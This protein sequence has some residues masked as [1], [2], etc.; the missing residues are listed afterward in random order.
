MWEH[1]N[2]LFL[3]LKEARAEGTWNTRPHY[4]SRLIIEGVHLFQGIT[5]STMGH[6]EGWQFLQIGRFL[7]RAG[8][9]AE[10]I[11]FHFRDDAISAA[12]A[13]A[14]IP[15]PRTQIALAGLLRSCSAL[16]AYCRVYTANLRAD[17]IAEF[18]LL[19]SDFPHSVRFAAECVESSLRARRPA[20]PARSRRPGRTAGGPAARVT[21]LRTGRRDPERQPAPVPRRHRAPVSADS[22]RRAP[23]LYRVSDRNG[24]SGVKKVR[25]CEVRGAKCGAKCIV[26]RCDV[27]CGVAACR[28]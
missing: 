13:T 15:S 24:D 22:Q 23:D 26:R 8:A 3:R 18:L 21:R 6:G 7:E 20:Q 27:Q 11:D 28:A 12:P 14:A 1:L 17:Q 5:D 16:E 10:L 19:N 4:L 2:G 9:T 25:E